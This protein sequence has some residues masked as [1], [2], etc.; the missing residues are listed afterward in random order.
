MR[1]AIL[2]TKCKIT[3]KISFHQSTEC[4]PQLALDNFYHHQG[5]RNEQNTTQSR[6][7]TS[8]HRK[9]LSYHSIQ[10]KSL[11]YKSIHQVHGKNASLTIFK[12]FRKTIGKN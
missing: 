5:C 11:S 12:H 3:A 8:K 10:Q 9:C 6:G 7:L 2:K 4:Y 1:R